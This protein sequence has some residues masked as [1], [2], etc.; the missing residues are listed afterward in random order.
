M[1]CI[2]CEIVG[3]ARECHPIYE[4]D[5]HIAFLDKYPIDHGHSLVI[6]KK[7][8]ETINQMDPQSIG[9]LFSIIPEIARNILRTTGASAFNLA[10]NNGRDARQIVPHVH[11]HIIPRYPGESIVW[12]KRQIPPSDDL[13][14]L[15]QS[16]RDGRSS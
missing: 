14:R 16:I 12:T 8:Y 9:S 1:G 7:H 2:F 13:A 11:V 3:S 15:A 5:D 10:Q 6:P 4:D